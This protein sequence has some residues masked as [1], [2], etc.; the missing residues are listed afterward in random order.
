M[1]AGHL[2]KNRNRVALSAGERAEALAAAAG[3]A[4]ISLA[5]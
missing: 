4:K 5:P 1:G 2:S 3:A